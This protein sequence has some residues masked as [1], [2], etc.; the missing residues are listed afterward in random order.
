MKKIFPYSLIFILLCSTGISVKAQVV[1]AEFLSANHEGQ[2]DNSP[3]N[4]GKSLYY[5][6]EYNNTDNMRINYTLYLYK[7]AAKTTPYLKLPVLMRNLTW[8]YF[9]DITF[10]HDNT[11]KVA[12]LILKK[13]LRW[14][15]FK[16]SPHEGF[17][18]TNPTIWTRQNMVS[19]FEGLLNNTINQLDKNIFLDKYVQP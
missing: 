18:R 17:S 13:D 15:R 4:G 7:D 3:N 11:N 2:V 10:T 6:F 9:L 8:T 1:M 12:A 16:F 19:N 14:S 5:K